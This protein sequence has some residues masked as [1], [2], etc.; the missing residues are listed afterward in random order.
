MK[1]DFDHNKI[2]DKIEEWDTDGDGKLDLNE[3]CKMVYGRYYHNPE[4]KDVEHINMGS[5]IK[6]RPALTP[7]EVRTDSIVEWLSD[8]RHSRDAFKFFDK[9]RNGTLDR[10]E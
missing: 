6:K 9:D 5:P 3:F 10:N 7:A 4:N 1:I 2:M 8:I